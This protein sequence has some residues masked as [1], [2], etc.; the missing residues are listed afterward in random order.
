MRMQLMKLPE[1]MDK[2][3]ALIADYGHYIARFDAIADYLKRRQPPALMLWGRH[4]PF[5]DL[6]ETLS[7]MQALPRMEA[8]VFDAGHMLLETHAAA[9]VSLMVDFIRVPPQHNGKAKE[10][11]SMSDAG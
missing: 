8:H 11:E 7:W 4:D 6:A 2:E 3:R 9:A 1:R 5:F 10:R